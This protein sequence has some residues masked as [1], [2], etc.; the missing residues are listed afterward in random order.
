MLTVRNL[1]GSFEVVAHILNRLG[2][3]CDFDIANRET[4]ARSTRSTVDVDDGVFLF[5]D[6][7]VYM[8][9]VGIL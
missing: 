4:R 9:L 1:V 2:V 8:I 5:R 3:L 7:A 6:G